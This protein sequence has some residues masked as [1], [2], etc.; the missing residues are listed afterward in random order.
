[1]NT[2]AMIYF[3]SAIITV[4]FPTA[5]DIDGD[6]VP[7]ARI[8]IVAEFPT[9]GYPETVWKDDVTSFAVCQIMKALGHR[10]ENGNR[11]D[12]TCDGR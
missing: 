10:S 8:R 9:E 5:L 3:L 6:K 1:M 12:I 11:I 7:Y 2:S 4:L